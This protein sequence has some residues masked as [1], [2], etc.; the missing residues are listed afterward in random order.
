MSNY[1]GA[2]HV[3]VRKQSH[4][5][6]PYLDLFPQFYS[7]QTKRIAKPLCHFDSVHCSFI[8]KVEVKILDG[9]FQS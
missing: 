4:H 6:E 5:V 3:F 1:S 2:F 7:A 9:T 8:S